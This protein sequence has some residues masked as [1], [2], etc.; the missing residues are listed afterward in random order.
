MTTRRRFAMALKRLLQVVPYLG[1]LPLRAGAASAI[2]FDRKFYRATNNGSAV[3]ISPLLHFIVA[4]AFD[5][6]KPHPLFDPAFYLERYPDVRKAGVNP[7]LHF[8]RYGA[9]EGRKPHP[10]FQPDYYLK[11]CMEARKSAGNPLAHFLRSRAE[12][13]ASP[14]LLFDCGCYLRYHPDL[15]AQSVNPLVHYASIVRPSGAGIEGT[16]QFGRRG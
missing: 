6:R 13:C 3:K 16:C 12:D 14:H 1:V 10:L 5:G 8:I 4:G 7:L 9:P 11:R 2:F 15:V